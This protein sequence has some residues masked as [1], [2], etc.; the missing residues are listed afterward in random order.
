MADQTGRGRLERG[1]AG[2]RGQLG[3]RGPAS[4]GPQDAGEGPGREE[5]DPAQPR[6]GGKSRSGAGTDLVADRVSLRES[7]A[8]SLGQA[9]DGR[10]P[11]LIQGTLTARGVLL[12]RGDAGLRLQIREALLVIRFDLEE[13]LVDLA[14]QSG[15]LGHRAF[16]LRD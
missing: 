10:R 3:L 9:P 12:N 15:C 4:T 14:P 6:Q 7:Q 11:L 1:D 8:Q 5:I 2:I 16:A 13:Q